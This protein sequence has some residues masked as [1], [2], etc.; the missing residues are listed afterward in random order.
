MT[1]VLRGLITAILFASSSVA[2]AQNRSV[3]HI[4][5]RLNQAV[6]T[7]NAGQFTFHDKASK[8]I[9]DDNSS[10]KEHTS[11]CFFKRNT[12]DS[13][14][15]YQLSLFRADGYQ[16]IY[17]G[18][19]L[20]TVYSQILE[21]TPKR[22][23][24]RQIKQLLGGLTGPLYLINTNRILQYFNQPTTNQHLQ[25]IGLTHFMDQECYQ[26]KFVDSLNRN[27]R[28]EVDY[29]V[30]THSYLPLRTVTR[31]TSLVGKV[32]E[33]TIF[34]YSVTDV[35]ANV[36]VANPFSR[37]MLTDY[38]I[39]KNY[40]LAEEQANDE[41]LPIGSKAPTW[42][43]PLI[44]GK[45][46]SLEALKGKI[47]I[48]DFWFKACAPCQKQMLSLQALHE[49]YSADKVMIVGI[50]TIDDPIKDKLASFLRN[51]LITMR[52]VYQGHSIQSLY[53]VYG[54]PAL[55]VIDKQGTIV[56]TKS[57][58]SNSLIEDID[59]VL[60]KQLSQ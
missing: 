5:S 21:V 51:R 2:Q 39:E 44:G 43:L 25:F 50:N 46:L 55:F 4:L 16:Q 41:L 48:L 32:K 57:G 11:R 60:V 53:K 10:Y 22:T 1:K 45:T 28:S 37:A 35:K 54:S 24:P 13:L 3:T 31:L 18:T 15:G 38:R 33:T 19:H 42:R 40:N 56:Y 20:F 27:R 17:D 52:S 58:Y 49:R 7:F 14:I 30:S 34:D 26:L 29:Y 9:T 47:I 6:L 12:N 59:R 23:Y 36:A 8:L